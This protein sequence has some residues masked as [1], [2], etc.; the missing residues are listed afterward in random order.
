MLTP[1]PT[2]LYDEVNILITRTGNER[3]DRLPVGTQWSCSF[4]TA[5]RSAEQ[6]SLQMR[7]SPGRLTYK[8]YIDPHRVP[9]MRAGQHMMLGSS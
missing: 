2:F 4:R 7:Q 3:L 9:M 5:K 8:N 1:P 6:Y